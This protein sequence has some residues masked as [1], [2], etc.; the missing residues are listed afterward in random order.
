MRGSK[1]DPVWFVVPLLILAVMVGFAMV[2]SEDVDGKTCSTCGGTGKV[3]CSSC[4]GKG[5]TTCAYDKYTTEYDGCTS[6]GGSSNAYVDNDSGK[7]F[8]TSG[9]SVG[10]GKVSCST[11][12]GSGTVADPHTHSYRLSSTKSYTCGTVYTYSC[13]CGAS[14][15]SGSGYSSHNYQSSTSYGSCS[16]SKTTYTCSRCGDS[17]SSGTVYNSH[18]WGSWTTTK[19]ATCTDTGT[20]K[21][22]C[23]RCS[24]SATQTI[25]ALGHSYSASTYSWSSDYDACTIKFVC[26]RDSSHSG[27]TTVSSTS[28]TSGNS[29]TYKVSGTNSTY[30]VSYSQSKTVYIYAATLSYDAGSGSGAP[31]VQ[32]AYTT[33]ESSSASGS[34]TFTISADV[35]A[36][37]GYIFQGWAT[38]SGAASANYQPGGSISVPY[39]S[40]VTLY[41]VW[42]AAALEIAS[43]P[44]TKTLKV[45]QEWTYTPTVNIAGCTLTVT[46]A[47]WLSVSDGVISGTPDSYGSYDVT[48]TVSKNGGYTSGQQTFSL[49][50]YSVLGFESVPSAE[51][52][53]AYAS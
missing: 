31:S 40:T 36:Y 47:D 18:N 16:G 17:Y 35:P 5:Y 4:G 39:G 8:D 7:W 53:F 26:S 32:T 10:S 30:N 50:V 25:S 51:G 49:K 34:K 45:G 9:Y 2:D 20:Q 52:V 24:T 1:I 15:T 42:K 13:S 19:A 38:S 12:G 23:T 3:T 43:E 14:Y 37:T 44:S 29:T 48:I 22:T 27:T 11:C 33:I 21:H 6:C 41:A 28:T 46:G